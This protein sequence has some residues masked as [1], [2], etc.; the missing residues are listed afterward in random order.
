[1]VTEQLGHLAEYYAA[2]EHEAMIREES[3]SLSQLEQRIDRLPDPASG[4][5]E[6]LTATTDVAII[7]EHKR[8]SPSEG[9]IAA[10]LS[11]QQVVRGYE[12]GGAAAV[13][14]LTQRAD[15]GG[16]I[17][18]LHE[19]RKATDLPLLRKD[20]ISNPYQL[21][22][23]RAYG[24][25]AVLL[26]VAGLSDNRLLDLYEE[27]HDIGLDC[28]VEVHDREELQRAL[29]IGP[30]L[31]GINNRNLSTLAVDLA[32]V[33]D[34]LEAV[35]KTTA[36]VAESGYTKP[37]DMRGLRAMKVDAVLVGTAVMRA[38]NQAKELIRW[39]SA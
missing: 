16:F 33:P 23:A 14:V 30:K 7:A 4:F 3:V 11:V 28:L 9:E 37:E 25:S 6:A 20:F 8:Q 29:E 10:G 34:L 21:Y 31:L 12:R 15:F 35:P 18:D 38:A 24:A 2:A 36:V 1:M 5:I 22:E 32:T 13:S 17:E 39:R 19:A 26:I 27:A